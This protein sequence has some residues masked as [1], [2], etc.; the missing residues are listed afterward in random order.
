V[1]FC[2]NRTIRA[3]WSRLRVIVRFTLGCMV[4]HEEMERQP[5]E[6]VILL[7]EDETL[8]RN[9]I[10]LMLVREGYAVL[11]A[12]DGQEALEVLEKF[13]D[14]IHLVVTD[15]RMPRL[16]GWSLA[17]LVRKQRPETKVIVISG[18][19]ATT[20]AT[21]NPADAFLRKPFI[22]PTFLECIQRVLNS[23]FRGVCDEI[24]KGIF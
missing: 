10:Q 11:A 13:T 15:V 22:P 6:T 12:S 1:R 18:E 21:E 23:G 20:I 4:E 5:K 19:T 24:T 7:A 14:P 2:I 3:G 17:E 16:D 8:V 9:L